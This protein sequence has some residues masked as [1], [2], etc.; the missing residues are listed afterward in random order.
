MTDLSSTPIATPPPMGS[1]KSATLPLVLGISVGAVALITLV[2]G[3]FLYRQERRKTVKHYGRIQGREGD[4]SRIVTSSR[5]NDPQR[6]TSPS[7]ARATKD[8]L[9]QTE[10][11]TA[12][13]RNNGSLTA[14]RD[15]PVERD[16]RE[17]NQKQWQKSLGQKVELVTA[18]D[19]DGIAAEMEIVSQNKQEDP[20]FIPATRPVTG[21][22]P[23]PQTSSIVGFQVPSMVPLTGPADAP[24][25]APAVMSPEFS[26]GGAEDR[27][28]VAG[29]SWAEPQSSPY[30]PDF[31]LH[32]HT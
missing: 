14:R 9:A 17:P 15:Y 18:V 19:S 5:G 26:V 8:S 24:P 30:N 16:V 13:S 27:H 31:P 3:M 6:V 22:T 12:G 21:P 1:G 20:T 4:E 10:Q 29:M 2:M 11:T 23:A 28:D 7:P 32:T 25:S